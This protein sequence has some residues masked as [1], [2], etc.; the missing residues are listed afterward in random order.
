VQE[1]EADADC[2]RVIEPRD[3]AIMDDLEARAE[4]ASS[5]KA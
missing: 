4:A 5:A 1:V 2:D 3:E